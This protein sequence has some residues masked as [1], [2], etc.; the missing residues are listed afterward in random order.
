[1]A[2]NLVSIIEVCESAHDVKFNKKD[3]KLFLEHL[4][5]YSAGDRE[6]F[7]KIKCT[8]NARRKFLAGRLLL[9]SYLTGR[10]P[11]TAGVVGNTEVRT[12]RRL[13]DL[14]MLRINEVGLH[15]LSSHR[16]TDNRIY[17]LY[18]RI[19][20]R[21]SDWGLPNIQEQI[22]SIGSDQFVVKYFKGTPVT[23]K[24]VLKC[25]SPYIRPKK[26]IRGNLKGN[27]RK[28]ITDEDINLIR[29]RGSMYN[30]NVTLAAQS[31]PYSVEFIRRVFR[32]RLQ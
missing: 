31:L 7:L 2:E 4:E 10:T 25:R 23:Y 11:I 9:F 6:L 27:E 15:E 29:S 14:Y 28:I 8:E 18:N 13:D 1:M 12:V 17:S 26:A 22:D 30:W 5:R 19:K 16:R 3:K 32:S 21:E 20:N 24:M